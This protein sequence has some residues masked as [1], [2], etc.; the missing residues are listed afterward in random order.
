MQPV[1][2]LRLFSLHFVKVH[3]STVCFPA[4]STDL[5]FQQDAA[6][7][8]VLRTQLVYW[9]CNMLYL[10]SACTDVSYHNELQGKLYGTTSLIIF[11]GVCAFKIS[12]NKQY[13]NS[14]FRLTT[15]SQGFWV[16]WCSLTVSWLQE[17]LQNQ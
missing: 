3:A 1:I 6:V 9:H 8:D 13:T 14:F 12:T 10:L 2:L 16:F 15:C 4:V 11:G 17:K 5:C 7:L